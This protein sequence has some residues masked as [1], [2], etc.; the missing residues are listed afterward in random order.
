MQASVR[1]QLGQTAVV[2]LLTLLYRALVGAISITTATSVAHKSFC[3][4]ITAVLQLQLLQLYKSQCYV[5]GKQ[6]T[7]SLIIM[8]N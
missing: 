5:T 8:D 2:A 1:I 6:A 7:V 4:T 3:F